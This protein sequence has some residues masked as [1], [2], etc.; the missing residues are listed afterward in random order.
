MIAQNRKTPDLQSPIAMWSDR[1]ETFPRNID[2]KKS[3]GIK[4]GEGGASLRSI[5]AV[6]PVP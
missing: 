4:S 5:A 1:V 3:D 2:G 6:W